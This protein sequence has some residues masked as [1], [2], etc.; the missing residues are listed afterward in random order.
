MEQGLSQASHLLADVKVEDSAVVVVVVVVTE[1]DEVAVPAV[2]MRPIAFN[3]DTAVVVDG[4]E[5]GQV[6]SEQVRSQVVPS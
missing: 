2:L 4:D 6:P 5:F 1:E 3:A